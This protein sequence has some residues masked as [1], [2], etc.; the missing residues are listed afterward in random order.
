MGVITDGSRFSR[1]KETR[2]LLS[3]DSVGKVEEESKSRFDFSETQMILP[4][5]FSCT[6]GA[7]RQCI[8]TTAETPPPNNSNRAHANSNGYRFSVW[9]NSCVYH[10]RGREIY[11]I[12]S[13]FSTGRTSSRDYDYFLRFNVLRKRTGNL[14]AVSPIEK[15]IASRPFINRNGHPFESALN[16]TITNGRKR[17]SWRS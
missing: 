13:G 4:S 8:I 10:A 6:V 2:P 9:I 3:D 7:A 5:S 14:P 17:L 15:K 12:H 1:P 11:E 16:R